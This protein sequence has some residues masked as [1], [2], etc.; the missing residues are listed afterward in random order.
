MNRLAILDCEHVTETIDGHGEFGDMMI[1]S[2][3]SIGFKP[4]YEIFDC[5]RGYLPASISDFAGYIIMGSYSG[6]YDKDLWIYDLGNF[7]QDTAAN[8][9]S[10][11]I[12]ICFG[13]QM[14]GQVLGGKV[15]KASNGWGIGCLPVIF[16]QGRF[17]IQLPTKL[18]LLFSHG[19]QIIKLPEN[20][21]VIASA[22]H[23]PYAGICIDNRI[24][25]LQAHPEFSPDF[26]RKLIHKHTNLIGGLD[27]A[28]HAIDSLATPP[29]NQQTLQILRDFLL[30]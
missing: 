7:I 10:K 21:A 9:D 8:S 12:G 30:H 11:I 22:D 15:E 1:D 20:A 23:C 28:R 16:N 29:Q 14:I 4:E 26:L 5:K 19:D 17:P 24:L 27:S 18:N 2:L 6:A 3:N 13:H 25:G